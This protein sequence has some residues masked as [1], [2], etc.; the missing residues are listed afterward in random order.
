MDSTRACCPSRMAARKRRESGRGTWYAICTCAGCDC[1][2]PCGCEAEP[3]S[4][5]MF[6]T[7]RVVFVGCSFER[8]EKQR[9]ET[10]LTS[11]T[12]RQCHH[13][14]GIMMS[15][16][17]R[18]VCWTG[19]PPTRGDTREPG[20]CEMNMLLGLVVTEYVL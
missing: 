20:W 10:A 11:T 12:A 13:H 17:V 14:H 19:A 4:L 1:D 2:V 9:R 6:P 5:S 18:V 7:D 8:V 3:S 16:P 15:A